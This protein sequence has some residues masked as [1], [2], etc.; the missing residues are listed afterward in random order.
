MKPK[1][2]AALAIDALI[3]GMGCSGKVR[4]GAVEVC[5]SHLSVSFYANLNIGFKFV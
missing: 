1:Q 2:F 4:G 5:Q 3:G